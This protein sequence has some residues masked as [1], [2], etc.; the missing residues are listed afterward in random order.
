APCP[1]GPARPRGRGALWLAAA[2]PR[3]RPT[4]A[5]RRARGSRRYAGWAPLPRSELGC[6]R[7][8]RVPSRPSP[9]AV[10]AGALDEGARRGLGGQAGE[11]VVG[12]RAA[13]GDERDDRREVT[14]LVLAAGVAEPAP[15]EPA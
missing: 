9:S 4:R 8:Y 11:E 10:G 6:Q 1:V 5:A 14:L 2:R 15:A 7:G 3:R 13:R 12:R